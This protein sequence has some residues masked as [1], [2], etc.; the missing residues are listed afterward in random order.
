MDATQSH[1][2]YFDT[3]NKIIALW[4]KRIQFIT[5]WKFNDAEK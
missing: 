4:I 1:Y 2:T 5:H 3:I